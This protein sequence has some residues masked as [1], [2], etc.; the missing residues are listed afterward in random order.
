MNRSRFFRIVM[1]AL[2]LALAGA[3]CLSALILYAD[4]MA[5]RGEF[6]SFMEPVFTRERVSDQ[7]G[8]ILPFFALWGIGL[9]AA[10]AAK[11]SAR[12]RSAPR[13]NEVAANRTSPS[14]VS[15]KPRRTVARAALYAAALAFLA[16]GVLNGGLNDVLVK[17]I[18]ICTE[19]I[20]L[21]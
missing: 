11:G 7:L 9:L 21:G 17:A 20:G 19:C 14:S 18:N 15:E 12:E 10:G 3:L 8:R 5:R 13:K 16:L 4:G 6:A 1:M 2:T